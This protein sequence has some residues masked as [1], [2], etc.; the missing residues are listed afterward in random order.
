M[1]AYLSNPLDEA[2]KIEVESIKLEHKELTKQVAL[3]LEVPE[4]EACIT[5]WTLMF[6][7]LRQDY[8]VEFPR[9]QLTEAPQACQILTR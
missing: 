7:Q 1:S 8:M 9:K 5:A 3:A 4:E 6:A 2:L